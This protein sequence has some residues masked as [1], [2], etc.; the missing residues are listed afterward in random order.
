MMSQIRWR[1]L[2]SICGQKSSTCLSCTRMPWMQIRKPGP[3]LLSI[4]LEA[5]LH[6]TELVRRTKRPKLRRNKTRSSSLQRRLNRLGRTHPC[7][8]PFSERKR[9]MTLSF[10]LPFFIAGRKRLQK[11]TILVSIWT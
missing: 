10:W 8:W 5:N 9:L 4:R 2:V 1:A 7:G 6:S 11:R 3:G